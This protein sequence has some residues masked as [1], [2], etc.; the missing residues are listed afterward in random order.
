MRDIFTNLCLSNLDRYDNKEP[1]T[2]PLLTELPNPFQIIPGTVAL[3][4]RAWLWIGRSGF[5]SR[6]T[7][8]TCEPF[9][10]NVL[11]DVFG[12]PS[13]C[14]GSFGTLKTPWRF[15][16]DSKKKTYHPISCN[17]NALVCLNLE[18]RHLCQLINE[19]NTIESENCKLVLESASQLF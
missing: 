8:T 9:D 4:Q 1:L 2:Q 7:F 16:P 3:K 11:K 19:L 10:G 13:A 15:V 18:A 6:H 12:F 5:D 14:V 17:S